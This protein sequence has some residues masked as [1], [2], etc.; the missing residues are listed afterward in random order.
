MPDGFLNLYK[1]S[2]MSSRAAVDWAATFFPRWTRMGHAGTLDPLA[3]GVLVVAVGMATRLVEFVQQHPKEY[4]AVIRLGVSS[5]TDD[6]AGQLTMHASVVPPTEDEVRAALQGFVGAIAQVPP[7]HSAVWVAGT[8]AYQRARQGECVNL[9]PKVVRIHS[10]EMV[11][12]GYP[13]LTAVITCGKGT[14]IRA[15]ARD[16]GQKLGCGGH[17]ETLIR[18]RVGPFTVAA[19][20]VLQ[21]DAAKTPPPLLPM[22]AALTT[23]PRVTFTPELLDRLCAG[24][25]VPWVIEPAPPPD[26]KVAVLDPGGELVALAHIDAPRR[27]LLPHRI[28]RSTSGHAGSAGRAC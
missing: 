11:D 7:A 21:F 14:Y 6:A 15:V 22:A 10:L 28:L 20:H 5:D 27:R 24:K 19:A 8:R 1:P 9:A 3:E 25:P 4:R 16:L 12:Y 23:G 18:T 13:K 26:T 2:G 17:L